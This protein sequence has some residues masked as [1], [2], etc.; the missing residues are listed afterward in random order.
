MIY[1]LECRIDPCGVTEYF[2]SVEQINESRWQ[3][4][5]K[6]SE[7][8]GRRNGDTVYYHLGYCPGHSI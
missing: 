2:D 5:T 4:I 8:I 3:E 7:P 6:V 1:Q